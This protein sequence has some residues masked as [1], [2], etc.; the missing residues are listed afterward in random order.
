MSHVGAGALGVLVALAALAVHRSGLGWLVLACVTTL[1]AGWALRGTSRPRRAASYSVG[2][3]VVFGIAVSGRPEGDYVL[4]TD[5][6]GY[7]LMLVALAL[8]AL[9]VS[10]LPGT[11]APRT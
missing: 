6:A 3:L 4:A 5:V 9:T 2:W 7:S 11:G 1:A 8:V 10:T